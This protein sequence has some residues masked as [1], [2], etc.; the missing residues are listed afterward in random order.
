M[1]EELCPEEQFSNLCVARPQCVHSD[2]V[3][4]LMSK[5]STLHADGTMH[6]PFVAQKSSGDPY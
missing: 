6:M 2:P 5:D 1:T 3:H 4:C